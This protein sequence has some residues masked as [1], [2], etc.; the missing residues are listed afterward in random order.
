VIATRILA[1]LAEN[2]HPVLLFRHPDATDAQQ[3]NIRDSLQL[4]AAFDVDQCR[5]CDLLLGS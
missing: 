5:D 3:L 1:T 2:R 4:V